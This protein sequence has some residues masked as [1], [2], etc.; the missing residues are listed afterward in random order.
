MT[1]AVKRAAGSIARRPGGGS[2]PVAACAKA[3]SAGVAAGRRASAACAAMSPR[4]SAGA[5][6]RSKRSTKRTSPSRAS[7]SSARLSVPASPQKSATSRAAWLTAGS[8][9]PA[10]S[11]DGDAASS[12]SPRNTALHSSCRASEL[13]AVSEAAAAAD[14][15][16][17]TSAAAASAS[18]LKSGPRRALSTPRPSPA[19]TAD[20]APTP[21]L[22]PPPP[23]ATF[24]R[25]MRLAK[26]DSAAATLGER[27]AAVTSPGGA[28]TTG[29][30]TSATV[31]G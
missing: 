8:C 3:I 1:I 10:L 21:S 23:R 4:L 11:H 25:S 24:R 6:R 15:S 2:A 18:R 20:A 16:A 7:T 17:A 5:R 26:L 13:L 29:T 14:G 12:S 19:A 9:R 22:T 31:R 28:S 27:A 30:C